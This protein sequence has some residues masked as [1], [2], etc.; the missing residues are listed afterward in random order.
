MI[1]PTESGVTWACS[2]NSSM[3]G[4]NFQFLGNATHCELRS[5]RQR[6]QR[7]QVRRLVPRS[8]VWGCRAGR[9]W[10]CPEPGPSHLRPWGEIT[11]SHLPAS[12]WASAQDRPRTSV[13]KRSARR[14]RRTIVSPRVAPGLGEPD[15]ALTVFHQALRPH[16]LDGLRHRGPGDVQ[17]VGYASLDHLQVVLGRARRSPRSIPRRRDAIRGDSYTSTSLIAIASPSASSA[18]SF[19]GQFAQDRGEGVEVGVARHRHVTE[20]P[21]FA[22]L[23]QGIGYLLRRADQQHGGLSG[24]PRRDP[25]T[26]RRSL[27][28]PLGWLC[29]RW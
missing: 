10:A 27:P 9:W 21:A 26:C 17:S 14:W 6:V 4:A 22:A 24:L 2:R 13:R 16:A 15:R 28:W 19:T 3:P 18:V 20:P 25:R 29:R 5:H 1:L 12:V 23:T 8:P 7:H 11:C